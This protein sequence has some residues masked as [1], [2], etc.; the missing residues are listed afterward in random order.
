[1][2][3][4]ASERRIATPCFLVKPRVYSKLA[5]TAWWVRRLCTC[6]QPRILTTLLFETETCYI[7]TS[8][9]QIFAQSMDEFGQISGPVCRTILVKDVD[10][11]RGVADG[12]QRRKIQ[13]RRNQ[14]ASREDTNSEYL[15]KTNYLTGAKRREACHNE[16]AVAYKRR[17]SALTFLLGLPGLA[18]P[19]YK[20]QGAEITEDNITA[21]NLINVLEP[22]SM[23]SQLV[24]KRFE[25]FAIRSYVARIGALKIL[26]SLSQFNFVKA[27]FANIEVF[28]LSAEEMSDDALSPFNKVV[29]TAHPGDNETARF[30]QLP[31]ALQPTD[32]QHATPHH[33]WIDLLP[34][35]TMRD[36]I[37][38]QQLDD[39]S[40][41]NLCHAMR[42]LAPD[43]N[44]GLL[45]WRDPWDPSGWEVTE[46]FAKSWRWVIV[47]CWDLLHSTNTWRARRGERALFRL[48]S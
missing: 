3:T 37:F 19:L 30:S 23:G 43:Q 15:T 35:P 2:L 18:G 20:N 32:L 48:P 40:E 8:F 29:S 4:R 45:V 5:P 11:W 31:T 12:H 10:D 34:M 42:G 27:L 38:R 17:I 22:Y 25:D 39:L 1:M 26:P 47:G 36:N 14:R 44:P 24:M 46:E 41:E 21:V 28:G 7:E 9:A 13:N 33:P 6:H 16:T